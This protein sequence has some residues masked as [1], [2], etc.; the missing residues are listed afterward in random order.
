MKKILATLVLG[1]LLAGSAQAA[2]PTTAQIEHLLQVMD[3]KK[4]IDQLLP[5]MMQQSRALVDQQ[6]AS[7][8]ASAVDR[9]RVERLLA[10]QESTVRDMLSWDKLK[11]I[12]LRV[13]TDTMTADEVL[14]MTRFYE[15]PEGRSVMQKMPQ[16]IQRTMQEMQPI[17]EAAMQKMMQDLDAEMARDG[18]PADK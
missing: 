8:D 13:Y 10:A 18:K 15:S 7:S 11:P 6:L 4:V 5:A 17:A 2:P 12:Y 9:A 1:L 3:A 14:A 16:I